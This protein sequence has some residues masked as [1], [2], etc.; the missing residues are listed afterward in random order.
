[1]RSSPLA[2]HSHQPHPCSA[3]ARAVPSFA[4]IRDPWS[5]VLTCAAWNRVTSTDKPLA[6]ADADGTDS[7]ISWSCGLLPNSGCYASRAILKTTDP[8]IAAS[9]SACSRWCS[10]NAKQ[11]AGCLWTPS[12]SSC[13]L[14]RDCLHRRRANLTW[15]GVCLEATRA[16]RFRQWA[17][18]QFS[19]GN[20]GRCG[21]LRNLSEYT[22]CNQTRVVDFVGRTQRLRSDFA[23]VCR[24]LNISDDACVDLD[25]LSRHCL[26]SCS[27]ERKG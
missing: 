6:I 5:R 21:D 4:F 10:Q 2:L 16:G 11:G 26:N 1:M 25:S 22:H 14:M 27:K 8:A 17:R 15:S 7:N 19:N 24:L 20:R 23:Y 13:E 3:S 12:H 9:S 18:Q